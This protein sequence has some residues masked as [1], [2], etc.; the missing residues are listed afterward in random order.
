MANPFGGSDEA[1]TKNTGHTNQAN[2]LFAMIPRSTTKWREV[3]NGADVTVGAGNYDADG[4]WRNGSTALAT[5]EYAMGTARAPQ[6][7]VTVIVGIKYRSAGGSTGGIRAGLSNDAETFSRQCLIFDEYNRQFMG[8]IRPFSGS[9]SN[10]EAAWNA[11]SAD[12]F[13]AAVKRNGSNAGN[14]LYR[15]STT[16]TQAGSD[17]LGSAGDFAT[18]S[19]NRVGVRVTDKYEFQ[20]VL[21]YNVA[22]S[23]ADI[24]AIIDN[25]G[26]VISQVSAGHPT[27]KRLAGVPFARL[28]PGVW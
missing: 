11:P 28:N 16:T 8:S 7:A 26:A 10:L 27:P 12:V 22:L 13:G 20:Y 24:A 19:L 15:V 18:A 23:D 2:L 21:V 17:S 9:S 14:A 4:Y 3:V 25:P 5:V 1:L 6:D